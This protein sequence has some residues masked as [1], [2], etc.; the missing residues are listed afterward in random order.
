MYRFSSAINP[1]K[2]NGSYYEVNPND[3][4]LNNKVT[5]ED[6]SVEFVSSINPIN[7]IEQDIKNSGVDININNANLQQVI[8]QIQSRQNI[9]IYSFIHFNGD[10]SKFKPSKKQISDYITQK[11]SEY[12]DTLA[13]DL[14]KA[15]R[16]QFIAEY[17]K[18]LQ[19]EA[20][21]VLLQKNVNDKVGSIVKDLVSSNVTNFTVLSTG[22]GVIEQ[23][24]AYSA[25][26]NQAN[27]TS[28]LGP[29]R[30]YILGKVMSNPESLETEKQKYILDDVDVKTDEQESIEEDINVLQN[31]ADDAVT[32]TED[33]QNAQSA[34][35]LL[36]QIEQQDNT[37]PTPVSENPEETAG[38]L[39]DLLSQID[40]LSEESKETNDNKNC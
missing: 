25:M 37:E 9:G 7:K 19:D 21:D 2:I 33:I 34:E 28:V 39:D 23:A 27:I 12:E 3:N 4:K 26:L 15:Q 40:A 17:S 6:G 30:V 35:D 5:N 14:T 36:S 20:P 16:R 11:E 29:C 32:N 13:P 1:L 10:I 22:D 31:A 38:S 18:K 8:E 24:G